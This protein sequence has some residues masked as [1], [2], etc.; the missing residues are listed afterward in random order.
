MQYSNDIDKNPT[1]VKPT[2]KTQ[3]IKYNHKSTQIGCDTKISINANKVNV[4]INLNLIEIH[5]TKNNK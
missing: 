3:N 1:Q 5:I 4:K 2:N